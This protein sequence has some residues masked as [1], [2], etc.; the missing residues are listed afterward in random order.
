MLTVTAAGSFDVQKWVDEKGKV[1]NINT[2]WIR[3]N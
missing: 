1:H 3:F 2:I